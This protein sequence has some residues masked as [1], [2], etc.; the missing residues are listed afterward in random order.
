MVVYLTY[1]EGRMQ[2]CWAHSKR[3]IPG[4]TEDPCSHSAQRFC[5][6]ALAI[7]ARLK[8]SSSPTTIP[9]IRERCWGTKE[10]DARLVAL[11]DLVNTLTVEV[12][13]A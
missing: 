5:R 4:I 3:T 8:T 2:L 13:L 11:A 6:D 10:E 1:H 9:P 7:L 12:L